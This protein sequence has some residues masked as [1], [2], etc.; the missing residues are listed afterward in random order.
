M[1][2]KSTCRNPDHATIKARTR[3]DRTDQ[4]IHSQSTPMRYAAHCNQN[5]PLATAVIVNTGIWLLCR[6]RFWA[7]V[8]V[9][10]FKQR[11]HRKNN[12]TDLNSSD[13]NRTGKTDK[14]QILKDRT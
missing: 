8:P 10:K 14:G 5:S 11:V 7:K 2:G 1:Y 9:G 3:T 4:N 6:V 13:D 12:E